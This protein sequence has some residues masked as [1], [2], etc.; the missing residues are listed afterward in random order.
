MPS[1]EYRIHAHDCD[2]WLN[3]SGDAFSRYYGCRQ[4]RRVDFGFVFALS[5][6]VRTKQHG[7]SLRP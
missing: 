2:K 6:I 7:M 4:S 5:S 3:V 1:I